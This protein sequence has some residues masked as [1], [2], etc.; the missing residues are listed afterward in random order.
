MNEIHGLEYIQK[1]AFFQLPNRTTLVKLKS[2]G[3][4]ISPSKD[5][6]LSE[7]PKGFIVTD[8]CA[9]NLFHHLGLRNA[10][11]L[12]PNAKIWAAPGLNI[13]RKNIKFNGVFFQDPWPYSDELPL[14]FI[15]GMPKVNEVVFYHKSSKT[16]IV[17]DLF[18][19]LL[20]VS[21]IKAKIIFN[22][23]G[24][25]KKFA[26]SKL[27]IKTIDN[28]KLFTESMEKIFELEIDKIFMSHGVAV[29][30]HAKDLLIKA[31]QSSFK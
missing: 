27:F 24:T 21:G 9:P 1:I 28:K 5:L 22:L 11:E 29:E 2:G 19:N 14:Y 16:L 4:L 17:T 20:N 23:M 31:Y 12:F 7:I 8:I 13:K 6:Q 3:I 25:Y 30:C 18:F 26:I 15:N 10:Q